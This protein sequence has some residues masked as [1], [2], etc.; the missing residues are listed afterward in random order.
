MIFF[1]IQY[2]IKLPM[3]SLKI[4]SCLFGFKLYCYFKQN[5]ILTVKY[6]QLVYLKTLYL[7]RNLTIIF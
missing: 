3:F 1:N 2:E 5:L 7:K 6:F 4:I